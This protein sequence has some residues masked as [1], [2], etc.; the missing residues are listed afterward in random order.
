MKKIMFA[1]I[2][3]VCAVTLGTCL[4]GGCAGTTIIAPSVEI[5]K[6]GTIKIDFEAKITNTTTTA[7]TAHGESEGTQ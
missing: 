1:A 3:C 2:L 4:C 7:T 6:D 5:R